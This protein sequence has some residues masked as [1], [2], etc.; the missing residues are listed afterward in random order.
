VLSEEQSDNIYEECA[1]LRQ[2]SRSITA[3]LD[4]ILTGEQEHSEDDTDEDGEE[5][6][7]EEGSEGEVEV[8]QYYQ[9]GYVLKLSCPRPQQKKNADLF[10]IDALTFCQRWEW[11]L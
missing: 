2:R 9:Y 7:Q 1:H 3:A 10:Q 6:E 8:G 4:V 11:Q 5:S